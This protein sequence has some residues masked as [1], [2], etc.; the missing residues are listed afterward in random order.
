MSSAW[1]VWPPEAVAAAILS[2]RQDKFKTPLTRLI[3]L[4]Y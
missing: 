2:G 4:S 3:V 1:G